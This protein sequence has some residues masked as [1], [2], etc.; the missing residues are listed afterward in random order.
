MNMKRLILILA[1]L[2]VAIPMVVSAG[3]KTD[4]H[5]IIKAQDK[6]TEIEVRVDGETDTVVLDKGVNFLPYQTGT[7][8]GVRILAYGDKIYPKMEKHGGE[9]YTY[10]EVRPPE[11]GDGYE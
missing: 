7:K 4:L 5:V 9:W 1:A 6:D 10:I 8:P 3:S 2:I 11:D